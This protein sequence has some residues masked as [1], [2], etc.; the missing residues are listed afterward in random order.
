MPPQERGIMDALQEAKDLVL[1]PLPEAVIMCPLSVVYDCD[2][3]IAKLES[4]LAQIREKKTIALNYAVKNQILEET[5]YRIEEKY[6]KSR[7]LNVEKFKHVFP[8]EYE[9]IC[10]DI[11][12]DLQ[13]E[14]ELV[15][16][17]LPLTKI[18]AKIKKAALEAA[19]GVVLVKETISY[20]VVRK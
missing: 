2:N 12:R 19:P 10:A 11:V 17:K 13:R 4:T 18:D 5:E 3:L 14:I 6:R 15:G 1:N 7:T 9:E 8:V 20:Q 16:D